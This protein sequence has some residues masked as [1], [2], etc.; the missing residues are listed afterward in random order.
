[1]AIVEEGIYSNLHKGQE[2]T[3]ILN[4]RAVLFYLL[5]FSVAVREATQICWR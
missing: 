3:T 4:S 1:M 5:L 2:K